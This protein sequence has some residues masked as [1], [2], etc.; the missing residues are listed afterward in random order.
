MCVCWLPT[1]AGTKKNNQIFFPF[2]VVCVL[3][4]RSGRF[5]T[6]KKEEDSG[7]GEIFQYPNKEVKRVGDERALRIDR[8]PVL[9]LLPPT[10]KST[11]QY[12]YIY[13][14]LYICFRPNP[15]QPPS[16]FW[17]VHKREQKAR[18]SSCIRPSIGS[19]TT[20]EERESPRNGGGDRPQ[21]YRVCEKKKKTEEEEGENAYGLQ[22]IF[23]MMLLLD[24][25]P[26]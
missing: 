17:C 2:C 8:Q 19:S 21:Y 25:R 15:R 7:S 20:K 18:Q 5:F 13:I 26:E 16:L 6:R 24:Q 10:L 3:R 1:T 9:L 14:Y 11:T 23:P 12:I 4:E 22:R